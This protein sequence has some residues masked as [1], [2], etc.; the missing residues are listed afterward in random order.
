MTDDQLTRLRVAIRRIIADNKRAG[1]TPSR[2]IQETENGY[3]DDL[4][5]VCIGLITSAKALEEVEKALR[6]Y[7]DVEATLEGE[8]VAAGDGFG[9]QESV[10]VQARANA[11]RFAA[12]RRGE[13]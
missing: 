9:F 2:F 8:I 3:S 12:I 11:E 7:P 1:Y 4:E 5:H 10:I 13:A 6:R